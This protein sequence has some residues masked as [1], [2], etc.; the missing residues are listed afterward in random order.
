MAIS[1][2]YSREYRRKNREQLAVKARARYAALSDEE[3]KSRVSRAQEWR[4][5]KR[6][7]DPE[8]YRQKQEV[9]RA[10]YRNSEKG[11]AH[12]RAYNT[13][14]RKRPEVK[15]RAKEATFRH[16]H[17]VTKQKADAMIAEQGG[18]CAICERPAS[19]K[20]H[21]SRLH[22]DHSNETGQVRAMLCMNC[23]NGIGHFKHDP[24][25]LRSAA[26]YLERHR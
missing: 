2:E 11:K 18:L 26:N 4:R 10:R 20:G 9:R 25:L 3:K 23:N 17:G 8:D 1:K 24:A 21:C 6:E 14:Y 22:V 16:H 12:E 7:K 19:G 15:V 13:E 5:R